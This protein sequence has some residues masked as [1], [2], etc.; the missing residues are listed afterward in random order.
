MRLAPAAI[1]SRTFDGSAPR[2]QSA[3]LHASHW[4]CEGGGSDASGTQRSASEEKEAAASPA[5]ESE[6][7]LRLLFANVTKFGTKMRDFVEANA[8]TDTFAGVASIETKASQG[9]PAAR[10]RRELRKGGF[11]INS[12]SQGNSRGREVG[13]SSGGS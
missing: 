4:A 13:R 1:Y 12:G 2:A 6:R 5:A 9:A 3:K 10:L 7:S 11:A 8:E